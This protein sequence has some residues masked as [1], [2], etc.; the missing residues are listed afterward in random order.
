MIYWM[1]FLRLFQRLMSVRIYLS[2]RG[3][4]RVAN[5]CLTGWAVASRSNTLMFEAARYTL[6]L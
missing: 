6:R 4:I 5:M 3:V 2:V 1:G